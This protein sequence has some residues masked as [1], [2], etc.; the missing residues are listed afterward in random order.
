MYL[1]CEQLAKIFANTETPFG[2]M[3]MIF[4]GD[5]AQLPPVLG[6]ENSA[7]YSSTAG[8]RGKDLVDQQNALGKAMWHQITTVVMLRQNMRQSVDSVEDQKFRTALTNLRY[9]A[10]TPEDLEFFDTRVHTNHTQGPSICA[11]RF[12]NISII[13]GY[14]ATRDKLNEMG[15]IRWAEEHQQDLYDF[16]SDDTLSN[17]EK[18]PGKPYK[19]GNKKSKVTELSYEVQNALWH[20]PSSSTDNKVPGKLTVCKGLPIMIRHN[21]ATELCI[22][23][24]QEGFVYDWI[25]G[26][27]S[28]GQVIL[29]V[30]F[31]KLD[32]PP[33]DVQFEGLPLNVVPVPTM[34]TPVLCR[35][36]DD[37]RIAVN[38]K[39]VP[40]LPNFAMTDYA[41]QGKTRTSNV[42][43]PCYLYTHQSLYTALSRGVSA[44]G[45]LILQGIT[46]GRLQGGTSRPQK[47]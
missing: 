17:N 44:K 27:G 19:K 1:I 4:A 29:K 30:L 14:N 8:E 45:T 23:K 25:A 43:D 34:S 11:D 46:D 38:R 35:L 41:S 16:Y 33:Q 7:L 18:I 37:S 28:R 21:T 5:F 32:N 31:V 42:V 20:Q 22:T 2:G 40:V 13:T 26:K 6:K 39:Q 36:K 47:Q 15:T 24:G 9:K 3:N 12:R 10:C